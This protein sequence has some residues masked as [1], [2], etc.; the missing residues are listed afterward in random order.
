MRETYT[1]RE[2]E[3]EREGRYTLDHIEA[4]TAPESRAPVTVQLIP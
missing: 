3:R 1:E 2:R 4:V